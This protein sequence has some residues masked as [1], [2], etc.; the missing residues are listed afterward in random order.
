METQNQISPAD[1]GAAG[2][3]LMSH[4]MEGPGQGDKHT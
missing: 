1:V 3:G 4:C 2:L